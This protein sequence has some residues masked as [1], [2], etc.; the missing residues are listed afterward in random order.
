M[1]V[2]WSGF[3]IRE[4]RGLLRT[5]LGLVWRSAPGW[6]VASL[7]LVALQGLLPL[8]SLLVLKAVVDSVTERREWGEILFWLAL[9][10]GAAL[11][12]ALARSFSEWVQENQSVRV[13][14]H[15]FRVL[16]SQSIALDLEYYEDASYQDTLHRAQQEAPYRPTR[17]VS[18]LIGAGQ[19]AIAL[20]G[21]VVILVSFSWMIALLLL[22]ATFPTALARFVFARRSYEIQEAN[23][24]NERRAWYYHWLLT[25]LHG[26]AEIRLLDLG[27]LFGR[28][29]DESRRQVGQSRLELGRKR[30]ILEA[31]GQVLSTAAVFVGLALVAYNA[32]QG[33]IT[34]GAL[35]MY[36]A[37]FQTGVGSLQGL[38]RGFAGL[39]EDSLFLGNFDRFLKMAP[40][41]VGPRSPAPVPDRVRDGIA[42]ENV[43]FS[44]PG[45]ERAVLT[46]ID[47]RVPAGSIVAIVGENGA[48]KSTLVKLLARLYDP[49]GG[50]IS[51]D[52]IDLRDFDPKEWRTRLSVVLQDYTRYPVSAREN[53]WFGDVRA[54][55]R[56]GAVIAAAERA[57]ADR[58]I[59][60]LPAGYETVLGREFEG[61]SEISAGEWQKVALARTLFRKAPVIVL[62]EPTSSLDSAAEADLFA[63]FR[64]MIGDRIAILISHRFSTVQLADEII[65]IE[66]GKVVEAG[67]HPELVKRGGRY[68]EM[69]HKQSG[70]YQANA[71]CG[72]RNRKTRR[73]ETRRAE[74]ADCGLRIEDKGRGDGV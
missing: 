63:R 64:G 47:L 11:L 61:G 35:V 29:A 40:R 16:H 74:I 2:D 59:E 66:G 32:L 51:V 36:F 68:A 31:T 18:G 6:T 37:A 65:V 57:S 43:S 48:G 52:G 58:V 22:A 54:Q 20:A 60:R 67:S 33:T 27:E 72:L 13:T 15:V 17:I 71:D 34:I 62:D 28:R 12:T 39:Y 5:A 25:S 70:M 46:G 30:L 49:S 55:D 53:V 56:D 41:I 10:G 24:A 9:A 3:T 42:F 4:F 8:V 7:I 38:L 23:T 50:R 21:I 19:S 45:S 73:G 26:A 1:R 14:E 69:Y 44:Y